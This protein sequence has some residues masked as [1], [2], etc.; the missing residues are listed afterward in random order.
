MTKLKIR[1]TQFDPVVKRGRFFID[2]EQTVF[3]HEFDEENFFKILEAIGKIVNSRNRSTREM[4]DEERKE[5]IERMGIKNE[6]LRKIEAPN[7]M[8]PKD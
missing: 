5:V 1:I 2:K 8:P 4:T 3:L 7:W 6:E